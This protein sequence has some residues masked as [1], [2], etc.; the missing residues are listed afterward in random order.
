MSSSDE[1]RFVSRH[2]S[3]SVGGLALARTIGAER[4]VDL[5]SGA[6]LPAIPLR[7]AGAGGRWHLVES[8][9]MKAL[10]LR[11]F[12]LDSRLGDVEVYCGRFEQMLRGAARQHSF[13]A[14]TSR[15]TLAIGP[16]LALARSAVGPGGHALLW[17]GSS[18]RGELARCD[19]KEMGWSLLESRALGGSSCVVLHFG[20]EG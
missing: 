14:L 11:K 13:D 12:I 9:R 3:E 4:W 6:G 7:L 19:A 10:F 5:G 20:L 2:L 17:K 1:S 8:R 15:A 18:W 16:T